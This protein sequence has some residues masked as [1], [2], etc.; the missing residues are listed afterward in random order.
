MQADISGPSAEAGWVLW[1]RVCPSFHPSVRPSRH[2]LGIGLFLF[3]FKF[4]LLL[5]IHMNLCGQSQILWK[6]LF[7]SKNGENWPKIFFLSLLKSFG[8]WFFLNL[9]CNECLYYLL[10]SQIPYLGKSGSWDM[11]QN[12]LGQS[13]CRI[14]KS[15]ISL[16]PS[17]EIA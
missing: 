4:W 7:C 3:F 8:Y 9:V 6:K 5:E 10:Y 15:N 16:E 2:F 14:S 11:S 17:S 12:A 13:D 1:N